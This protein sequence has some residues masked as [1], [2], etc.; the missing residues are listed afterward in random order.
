MPFSHSVPNK[1][2]FDFTPTVRYSII[3]ACGIALRF[4]FSAIVDGTVPYPQTWLVVVVVV[5]LSIMIF[6]FVSF[7]THYI[8][9]T[10][11]DENVTPLSVEVVELLRGLTTELVCS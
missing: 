2:R 5:G 6:R 8:V 7:T 9:L 11:V 4:P 1:E 10:A 3:L